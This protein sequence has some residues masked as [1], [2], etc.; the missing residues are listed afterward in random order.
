MEDKFKLDKLNIYLIII[1]II[2]L[3]IFVITCV[4]LV[5]SNKNSESKLP[6]LETTAGNTSTK[7]AIT[8]TESTTTSIAVTT[9][10]NYA[11][12]NSP[13]YSV[14]TNILSEDIYKKN[15]NLSSEE[16]KSIVEGILKYANALYDPNDYSIFN[17]DLVNKA[18]KD[19][20]SDKKV[21]NGQVYAELYNFQEYYNNLYYASNLDYS[22]LSYKDNPVIIKDG[23]KY[24]RLITDLDY[25]Y[26]INIITITQSNQD[27]IKAVISYVVSNNSN[28]YKGAEITLA[29]KDGWKVKSY[30]YPM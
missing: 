16:S 24:Y 1:T 25:N 17:T 23:N 18:A 8:S 13:Y 22:N 7:Y 9:T 5:K 14:N 3:V 27:I 12:L 19:G 26:R 11:A 21:I 6:I 10:V 30:Q 28:V 20:E 15:K 29:Y 2:V 4:R